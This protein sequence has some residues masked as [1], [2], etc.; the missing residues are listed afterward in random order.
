MKAR[1]FMG[2]KIGELEHLF[3]AAEL[4]RD[5]GLAEKLAQE[6]GYRSTP[7]AVALK[8]KVDRLLASDEYDEVSEVAI[9]SSIPDAGDAEPPDCILDVT[10]AAPD[11]RSTE[12]PRDTETDPMT[13]QR[14]LG[15]LQFV[16]QTAALRGTPSRSVEQHRDFNR[17]ENDLRGLPGIGFAVEDGDDDIWLRV[18]RLHETDP[19]RPSGNVLDDLIV[20]SRSTS[21]QPT[22]KRLIGQEQLKRLGLSVPAVEGTG[23]AEGPYSLEDLKIKDQLEAELAAYTAGPWNAW[24]N[25][26]R[27][28]RRTI[29]LYGELF[30]VHQKLQGNLVETPLELVMGIGVAVWD[31]P[32]GAIRYPL[33][34]KLVEI[35]VNERSHAIEVRPRALD[36]AMELDAYTAMDNPGVAAVAKAAKEFF[37]PVGGQV[38]PFEASSFESVLTT[39]ASLLDSKGVYW[40]QTA[41]ADDRRVPAKAEHL[42]VT[43]TWVLFVRPRNR[44]LFIQDLERFLALVESEPGLSSISAATRALL[45]EPTDAVEDPVPIVYRG[46][47]S[48]DGQAGGSGKARDLFFPLPY[49]DEQVQIIQMLDHNDGVVVQGPP[50]TG[51]THTIANVISNYLASGKRVLVT[52]MKDPA[53]AVLQ[54]MLP[55]DIRPLAISLLTSEADGMK[56]FEHA[57]SRISS[58]VGRINRSGMRREVAALDQRIDE[59]H[60]RIAAVDSDIGAWARKNM[61]PVELDGQAMLPIDIAQ[62]VAANLGDA[63]IP[64][65]LTISPDHAPGFENADIIALREARRVLGNDLRLLGDRLP[66]IDA[67][68]GTDKLLQAHMDLTRLAELNAE[69]Q[70]ASMPS[71]RD[72]EQSTIESALQAM[73]RV[74]SLLAVRKRI[75]EAEVEWIR[76]LEGDLRKNGDSDMLSLFN[77]LCDDLR[78]AVGTRK[79]FVSRPVGLPDG[80]LTDSEV[81]AAI[82]NLSRGQKPFGISGLFGKGAAKRMLDAV[83]ILSGKPASQED[84]LH[85]HGFVKFSR[86]AVDLLVRWKALESELSI[87][88]ME[89]TQ[90]LLS[91]GIECISTYDELRDAIV[92]EASLSARLKEIFPDWPDA[93]QVPYTAD[94]LLA[95][96]EV[97]GHNLTR[98]RLADTWRVKE[99]FSR[100]LVDCSGPIVDRIKSFLDE[101]LGSPALT[102]ARV[103]S[104]WSGLMDELRRLHSLAPQVRSVREVTGKIEASGARGWAELLRS[105][106]M[107]TSNDTLLPDDWRGAWRLRR[108]LTLVEEMDGRTELERLG[109]RRSELESDLAALYQRAVTTR[110]WLQLSEKASPS[111]RSALEAY[112]VA[113]QKIGR[114]TGI[115]AP[116]FRKDARDAADKASPAI[117][118]WIMPHYRVSES[119]PVEFGT[120]DLVIIDEASQSDLSALPAILRAKKVLIVGDD[121]QV[122][123]DG[124]GLEEEKI[125][126]LMSQYLGDQV[127]IYR[128]QMSPDRSIYDLF[129]VVFAK[130]MVMLREHFR[131]VEPIIEYSK[132][133]FYNHELRPLR[134]PRRSERLDPPLVDVHV[135]DGSR[136]NGKTNFGEAR[137]IVDE[138]RKIAEDPAM[139]KR[140]LGVVSL[141]GSE[142]TRLVWDLVSSELGEDVIERHDIA[143]GD[144]RT[145]QGKERDIMFLSMV[146]SGKTAAASPHLFAQRYNVA[147]SRA[148]DRMYLVR[149]IGLDELSPADAMRRGLIEHFRSPF[150]QGEEEVANA[151]AKCESDFER[152]VFDLL[153][154]R[155]Y[156]VTPQVRVGSYRIDMVVEGGN[157]ARLAIECDGDKY[158]GPERWDHDTRRQRILERAGWSFWRCFGSTFALHREAVIEDLVETLGRHGVEPIGAVD[159]PRSIYSQSVRYR[160]FEEEEPEEAQVAISL[161]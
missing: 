161:E 160:A 118:C 114:G 42:T 110:T 21:V 123:P 63:V 7:R 131:C 149:S 142:Q 17:Y 67:F 146:V 100:A 120:F 36:A 140:S 76:D 136:G 124:I 126:S 96:K 129:K 83:T 137:F 102:E 12:L 91:A 159:A 68:P 80:L 39:A 55:E 58:E 64:D 92:E 28:V 79:S 153:V 53:L 84:W 105:Q 30:A 138:I 22:I 44:S 11:G 61:E 90:D 13:A 113:V 78:Q 49:N 65:R 107:D 119:L 151:R 132:R 150:L 10:P 112:R 86:Q 25:K 141:V 77:S 48:I 82:E 66:A 93:G 116:R 26:E 104:I 71:L 23:N 94:R 74:E 72:M 54:G 32:D 38:S 31:H 139:R 5:L 155:G 111:V 122:S 59:L 60:A 128:A 97:L 152:E 46:V 108:L 121:K 51:K 143:F 16:K 88:R 27:D 157:D 15:L 47:S 29:S 73:E 89:T 52:S 75:D 2:S 117:P 158:H 99:Q 34:S 133:E 33:I 24:A 130:G 145:F 81:L 134:L 6:L 147:A 154:E 45:T 127:D 62:E 98:N 40:P 35:S 125:R 3:K 57:I 69:V 95:A 37:G 101:E 103:Q 43:D 14:L 144:A 156:R 115:R 1:S 4:Q 135:V 19:P 56:Q 109:K 9:D 41:A 87:A 70:S 8:L 20:L 106:P 50:G 18:E 148:R 85:V